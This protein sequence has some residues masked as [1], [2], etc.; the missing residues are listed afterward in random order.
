MILIF[1]GCNLQN[2]DCFSAPLTGSVQEDKFMTQGTGNTVVDIST[3]RPIPSAKVSIPSK[4]FNTVTDSG[5]RFYLNADL[6]GPTI[7]SVRAQ[8]YQ[9]FSL[10]IDQNALNNPLTLG[11]SKTGKEIVIDTFLHHLGDDNYSSQSANSDDFQGKSGGPA[12]SK[13]FYVGN[14]SQ[15]SELSLK[16]G[17]I[18]GVDTAVAVR[19]GQSRS[20]S[21]STPT[22]IFLNGKKIGEIRINGD[23]QEIAISRDAINLNSNN[24]ITV[25]TGKNVLPKT[26]VDY[27]DMEFM[28]LILEIR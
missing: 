25:I 11:I 24:L 4:N 16:I 13:N 20:Q 17:S 19:L 18:I 12:Y 26:F 8:G 27:D 5:G 22:K 28:N 14:V 10:T 9:P 1:F 6:H 21:F 7:L 2:P 15:N 23:N 3:G